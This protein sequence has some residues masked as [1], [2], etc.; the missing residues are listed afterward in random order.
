MASKVDIAVILALVTGGALWIEQGHWVVIDAPTPSELA[1]AANS[2]PA[3]ADNDATPYSANCLA[4]MFGKNWEA[5]AQRAAA[6][7][8][9]IHDIETGPLATPASCP[10]R[11]DVPYSDS[12]LA[13]LRGA[14]TLA[15][16]WRISAPPM[17]APVILSSPLELDGRG[18]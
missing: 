6:M 2:D 13:Y 11:D 18:R 12:C 5:E 15:M 8:N 9:P 17:A 1:A 10:D 3:C 14:T 7:S 4:F 16:R